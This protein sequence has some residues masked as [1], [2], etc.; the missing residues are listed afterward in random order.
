MELSLDKI[1]S[2]Y[3]IKHR[4]LFRWEDTR[5]LP[6]FEQILCKDAL[7]FLST[8]PLGPQGF[9][10]YPEL[11]LGSWPLPADPEEHTRRIYPILQPFAELSD[12]LEFLRIPQKASVG[13]IWSH[14]SALAIMD[15]YSRAHIHAVNLH[16][17]ILILNHIP[18]QGPTHG[19]T[20]SDFV[21]SQALW[22]CGST[23]AP[24]VP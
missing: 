10:R 15:A 23:K 13:V 21:G 8:N 5:C 3:S 17:K 6:Q 24:E 16:W 9:Q 4:K 1:I 12:I 20:L 18:L 11:S 22:N 7:L 19:A 2:P 14:G